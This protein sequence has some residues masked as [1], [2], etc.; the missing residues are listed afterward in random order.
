MEAY[1]FK[2]GWTIFSTLF[3]LGDFIFLIS[4][5]IGTLLTTTKALCKGLPFEHPRL[6]VLRE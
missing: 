2:T 3:I 1:V 5:T 6:K 4:N